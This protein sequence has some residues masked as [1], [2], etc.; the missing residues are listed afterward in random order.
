M[1]TSFLIIVVIIMCH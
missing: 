1:G